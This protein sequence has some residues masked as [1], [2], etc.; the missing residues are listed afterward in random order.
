MLG[1][2]DRTVVI[3]GG[4]QLRAQVVSIETFARALT[5]GAGSARWLVVIGALYVAALAI[6]AAL[7][8]NQAAAPGE[9]APAAADV[10]P[11][12]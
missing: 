3:V 8:P 1:E 4:V 10:A 6:C 5:A 12:P 2:G 9:H 11:V 7:A